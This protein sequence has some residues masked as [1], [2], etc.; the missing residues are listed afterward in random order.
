MLLANNEPSDSHRALLAKKAREL[1][2]AILKV[3][4]PSARGSLHHA[5]CVLDYLLRSY[6]DEVGGGFVLFWNRKNKGQPFVATPNPPIS[7]VLFRW[8]HKYT[9]DRVAVVA[10]VA[11]NMTWQVF[12]T[13]GR[14]RETLERHLG[15]MLRW[16][17]HSPV[18]ET[19]VKLLTFPSV[20]GAAASYQVRM[21]VTFS[22]IAVS[23]SFHVI[24]VESPPCDANTCQKTAVPR[25]G[26]GCEGL[27]YVQKW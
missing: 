9:S 21:S 11:F 19:M 24:C 1:T 2:A 8:I 10:C 5:C 3:F 14:S 22:Q 16:A 4:W 20:A 12:E 6:A 27:C 23:Y 7:P 15:P 13:L 26:V 18:S 25:G 17:E